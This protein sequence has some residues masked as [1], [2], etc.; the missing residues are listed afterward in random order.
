M[1]LLLLNI[2][3]CGRI[4]S[5]HRVSSPNNAHFSSS[6]DLSPLSSCFGVVPNGW[7][8]A[9]RYKL[10]AHERE[11]FGQAFTSFT[12]HIVR[13]PGAFHMSLKLF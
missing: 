2:C 13:L 7:A 12:V 9:I 6:E 5:P 11:M 1:F 4:I 10:D 3:A 8:S